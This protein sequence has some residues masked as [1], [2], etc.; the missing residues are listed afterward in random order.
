MRMIRAAG[1]ALGISNPFFRVH[2]SIAAAE[3]MID[4]KSFLNFAS[5]NYVGLNGDPRVSDAAK[6]AIDQYGTSVSA[7]RIVS[8]DRGSPRALEQEQAEVFNADDC[9]TMGSGPATN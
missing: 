4:G 9:N 2:D 8:G 5:Y 1:D 6:A 3:T 7:S